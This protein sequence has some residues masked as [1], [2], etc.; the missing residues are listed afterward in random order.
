MRAVVDTSAL[1]S[2][3]AAAGES[4]AGLLDPITAWNG[5][6]LGHEDLFARYFD[7]WGDAN[8]RPAAA[9]V[10]VETAARLVD[11]GVDWHR[12][13]GDVVARLTALVPRD[14]EIP[15][16]VFVGMGTSNGWV[17]RLAE[18]R[19]PGLRRRRV[20]MGRLHAPTV[21]PRVRGDLAHGS[22]SPSAGAGRAVRRPRRAAVLLCPAC[23][24]ELWHSY[25]LR[26]LRG[27]ANRAR[28]RRRDDGR[29]TTER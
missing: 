7:G 17:T 29:G 23:W 22:R 5:Y 16:V 21:A 25:P 18:R 24:R 13:L 20:P 14:L 27:V 26:V 11:G 6:E 19:L 12:L 15:V 3:I 8:K 4:S 9:A 1:E 28:P 10:M 2:F